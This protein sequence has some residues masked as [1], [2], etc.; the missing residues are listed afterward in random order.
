MG[1]K[2]VI[3]IVALCALL[4]SVPARADGVLRVEGGVDVTASTGEFSPYFIGSNTGGLYT[5]PFGALVRVRAL[6]GIDT[7]RRFS[8]GFG[9]DAAAGYQSRVDYERYSMAAGGM[10]CRRLGPPAAVLQELWGGV[11]YRGAYITVGQADYDAHI[12]PAMGSGDLTLSHNARP[13]P[14]VRVGFINFQNIPL[15][16]GWVQIQGDISYGRFTD[17]SWNERHYNRYNGFVTTGVWFHHADLHLRTNPRQP[18]SVTVGMQ[19]AAQFGG[20]CHKYRRGE[21]TGIIHQKVGIKEFFKIFIPTNGGGSTGVPGDDSYYFGNHL[22]SW[23]LTLRYRFDSGVE[24][25]AYAQTPWEDGSGIGKLNGFDGRWGLS[26]SLPDGGWL[27]E[28]SA[29][30]LDF[31]NQSGPIHFDPEDWDGTP[32]KGEATGSDDYYNNFYYNGWANY[33]MSIGTPF[34]RSPLYNTDG[35]MGF[36]YNRARGFHVG[37]CGSVSREVDWRLLVSYR[38]SH[39]TPF[40]PSARN[41]D[42]FSALVGAEWRVGRVE[43]LKVGGA[44]AL[45]AGSLYGA[46]AG[47]FAT[48]SY[49]IDISLGKRK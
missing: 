15:M 5:Q 26:L 1:N 13:I 43:G 9:A 47:I 45:D 24:L 40:L 41:R 18:F 14:G 2:A 10:V 12:F 4:M 30:Y 19:H 38:N 46:S 27:R 31:T 7:T 11:K 29:E 23:D 42:D 34:L 8:W 37:A 33:G 20:T 49:G 6:S 25:T 22:G 39:G 28:V 3:G 17:G 35:Y 16:R 44:V 32:I 36:L 48:V 21:Q